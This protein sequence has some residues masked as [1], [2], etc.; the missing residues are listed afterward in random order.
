MG[1]KWLM[2]LEGINDIGN[3]TRVNTGLTSD[4]LIG[5]LKQIIDRAHSVGLKVIGCTL[6]PYQGAGYA[7]EAGEVM[8]EAENNFIRTSGMF[9]AVVDF[10]AAV[11]DQANPKSF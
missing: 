6:T 3:Q 11:R 1:A 4:D 2:F 8:R 5:A 9:D 7:S 10:D